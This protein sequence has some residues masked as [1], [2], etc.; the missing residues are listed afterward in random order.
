MLAYIV[1]E[2]GLALTPKGL[3]NT[4]VIHSSNIETVFT[5]ILLVCQ[6]IYAPSLQVNMITLAI[7]AR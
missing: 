6:A 2:R 4:N 1:G 5:V 7:Y 3:A